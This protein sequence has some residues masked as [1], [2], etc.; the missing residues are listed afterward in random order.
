MQA[1]QTRIRLDGREARERAAQIKQELRLDSTK[2]GLILTLSTSIFTFDRTLKL[3]LRQLTHLL[4]IT[5]DGKARLSGK[6]RMCSHAVTIL[7][8]SVCASVAPG[9]PMF[10]GYSRSAVDSM[11]YHDHIHPAST[12][13][14]IVRSKEHRNIYPSTLVCKKWFDWAQP[15]RLYELAFSRRDER[16]LATRYL[17]AAFADG[18]TAKRHLDWPHHIHRLMIDVSTSPPAQHEANTFFHLLINLKTVVF[19]GHVTSSFSLFLVD[20]LHRQKIRDIRWRKDLDYVQDAADIYQELRQLYPLFTGLS[21]YK[22]LDVDIIEFS[23]PVHIFSDIEAD[24]YTIQPDSIQPTDIRLY[25]IPDMAKLLRVGMSGTTFFDFSNVRRL[26]LAVGPAD[27]YSI[28]DAIMALP[29]VEVLYL[30]LTALTNGF[31]KVRKLKCLQELRLCARPKQLPSVS[32]VIENLPNRGAGTD[33][34]IVFVHWKTGFFSSDLH[35]AL[36]TIDALAS[37]VAFSLKLYIRFGGLSRIHGSMMLFDDVAEFLNTCLGT[38]KDA[39]WLTLF[40]DIHEAC[41]WER[42]T[43]PVSEVGWKTYIPEHSY[44]FN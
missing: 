18:F 42:A 28:F 10:R 35:V 32:A 26:D 36:S 25:L 1:K 14:F 8:P 2:V 24:P 21:A 31:L 20:L 29:A 34:S 16:S 33:V 15:A 43:K 17:H 23:G 19:V 4:N 6:R 3:Q 37:A 22:M 12:S 7:L 30:D 11:A 40:W 39:G 9:P 44:T 5:F 41:M 13:Q 27:A 38:W